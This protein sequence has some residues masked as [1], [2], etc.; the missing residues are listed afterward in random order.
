[1]LDLLLWILWFIFGA[2]S[3]WFFTQ[4]KKLQPLTFDELVLL[5][6]LHKQEAHCD[7]SIPKVE[8]I[9]NKHQHEFVGFKCECGYQYLSKRLITQRD[10]RNLNMFSFISTKKKKINKVAGAHI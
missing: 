2:Y 7:A 9:M 8:P 6:K 5:W 10:A 1:M 3:F 4:A